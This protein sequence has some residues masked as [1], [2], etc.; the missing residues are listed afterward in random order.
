[1]PQTI[2]SIGLTN[3]QVNYLSKIIPNVDFNHI[4]DENTFLKEIQK[5]ATAILNRAAYKVFSAGQ[6][7]DKVTLIDYIDFECMK[8]SNFDW[9]DTENER[10]CDYIWSYVRILKPSTSY[11]NLHIDKA[12][13]FNTGVSLNLTNN[14]LFEIN[15]IR[16]LPKDSKAKK[17]SI[18]CFFDLLIY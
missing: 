1:M 4:Y 18:I 16:L 11:Y 7:I 8:L 2:N 17:A 15:K 12:D 13:I 14:Y 9:I 5:N 10:L 6:N 3:R